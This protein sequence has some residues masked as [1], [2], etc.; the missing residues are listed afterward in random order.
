[1]KF[2]LFSNNDCSGKPI[3]SV[4]GGFHQC[5]SGKIEGNG[6]QTHSIRAHG[7]DGSKLNMYPWGTGIGCKGPGV[8]NAWFVN[9]GDCAVGNGLDAD[10]FIYNP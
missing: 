2:D 3:K 7:G 10:H 9:G 6:P 8:A 5:L 1:M 4:Y